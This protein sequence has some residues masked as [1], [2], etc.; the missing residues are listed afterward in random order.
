MDLYLGNDFESF[1]GVRDIFDR[2]LWLRRFLLRPDEEDWSIWQLHGYARV[3]GVSGGVDLE[4]M[5][6]P[7]E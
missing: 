4:V 5:R 6:V 2:P 3:E 7:Q 1:Y